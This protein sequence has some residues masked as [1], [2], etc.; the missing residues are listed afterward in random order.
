[1]NR[2]EQQR[3]VFV[4]T[5]IQSHAPGEVKTVNAL[6]SVDF[7]PLHLLMIKYVRQLEL[8]KMEYGTVQTEI[9]STQ[10]VT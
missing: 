3:D 7:Q 10:L 2:Y 5:T 9:T 6:Q 4:K 8:M 1:M